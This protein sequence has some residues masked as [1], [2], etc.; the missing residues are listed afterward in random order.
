MYPTYALPG[1]SDP[2]LQPQ[3][4]AYDRHADQMSYAASSMYQPRASYEATSSSYG[5]YQPRKIPELSS[6]NPQRGNNGTRVY[7][8]LDSSSDLLGSSP[9][10]ASLMFAT[11]RI[12]AALNRLDHREHDV[13]DKYV[14]TATAP[15][16]ADTGSPNARIPL[17]LQ[18]LERSGLDAGLIDVGPWLYEDRKQREFR[19]APEI[20]RKRKSS[21][22]LYSSAKRETS[23]QAQTGVSQDFNILPYGSNASLAY[24][25]SLHSIDLTS[26]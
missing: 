17:R 19:S 6:Y 26:M 10:I 12:P 21:E 18:L 15:S 13:C 7:V 3:S 4:T 23:P 25:Q 24:P 5:E 20:T 9:L 22:E 16:F 11:R 14:V 2:N 1:L 8:Y